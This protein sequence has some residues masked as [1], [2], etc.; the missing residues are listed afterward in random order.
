MIFNEDSRVKLPA[1][2]HL[3]KMGYTY[4]SLSKTSWD[5]DTNIFISIFYEA[6]QKLNPEMD[7][8]AIKEDFNF[9]QLD[10]DF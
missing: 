8:N 9:M 1:I 3:T 10:K 7:M 2:L 4:L 6:I 5:Q